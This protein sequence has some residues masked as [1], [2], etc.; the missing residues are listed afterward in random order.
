MLD[1]IEALIALEKTGTVSEAAV[2]LRL[3]QSAVSK[4]IRALELELDYPLVE[5]DGRR[6]RLTPYAELFLAK[7][8]PIVSD[9]KSL[10]RLR[11][12][13]TMRQFS[14]G[15]SDSIASSWGPRL[16]KRA[17]AKTKGVDLEVHVHRSSLILDRV[18]LGRY[19]LG[20]ITGQP[21][22][23][24]LT[25]T[26]LTEEPMVL[27]GSGSQAVKERS[28]ILTIETVS[29]TWREI[30]ARALTQD[31][32]KGCEFVFLESFSAA[33]QMAKEGFGRAL[34]PLGTAMALGFRE[35]NIVS[36]SP[37]ISR[38]VQFVS[39]KSV[40][41]LEAVRELEAAL[42]AAAPTLF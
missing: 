19:E 41:G 4:R 8:K 28:R 32:F 39:R 23:T 11:D 36:L 10:K 21:T 15:I 40:H 35:P 31:R 2:Q 5:A 29:A 33:A 22:E 20:I 26:R 37:K 42:L 25:W 16:L 12:S 1:G 9:L 34:V 30:G 38:Q 27:V 7:A 24:E 6:L 13:P 14:I 3:T 17:I 18:K